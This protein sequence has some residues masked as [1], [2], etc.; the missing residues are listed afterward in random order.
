MPSS[1]TPPWQNHLQYRDRSQTEGGGWLAPRHLEPLCFP[2]SSAFQVA[3]G[4]RVTGRRGFAL[5]G[6]DSHKGPRPP[7]SDSRAATNPCQLAAATGSHL[8]VFS[9]FVKY[10]KARILQI[11]SLSQTRDWGNSKRRPRRQ[12]TW[13]SLCKLDL[14]I[15]SIRRCLR[16]PRGPHTVGSIPTPALPP[17]THLLL[18]GESHAVVQTA[19]AGKPSTPT[20]VASAPSLAVW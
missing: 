19:A 6:S 11:K 1:L 5:S 14:V 15:T 20:R 4:D 7:H 17:G 18:E 12:A 2:F 16:G 8:S 10:L 13:D 3:L 9:T